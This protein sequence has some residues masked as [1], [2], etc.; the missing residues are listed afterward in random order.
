MRV[1][2]PTRRTKSEGPCPRA[3]GEGQDGGPIAL[4]NHHPEARK[5]RS[6]FREQPSL[7]APRN[8]FHSFRA[9]K[10]MPSSSAQDLSHGH[11]LIITP[12]P[13]PD[14][15]SK[16]TAKNQRDL[17]TYKSLRSKASNGDGGAMLK[18]SEFTRSEQ[19][20]DPGEPYYAYWL[21]Q[22]VRLGVQGNNVKK[23]SQE[24]CQTQIDRRRLDRW[25][26][27]ACS[28]IDQKNYYTDA[29]SQNP[30]IDQFLEK[31]MIRR[32]ESQK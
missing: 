32:T 8:P 20:T 4:A 11:S 12:A 21:F 19:V 22:A 31:K 15:S 6:V 26:D 29:S 3:A 13:K 14:F 9:T 2:H 16:I 27:S 7:A 23:K 18:M 30:F 25:F 10:P 28:S 1:A 5:E 24:V 17:E